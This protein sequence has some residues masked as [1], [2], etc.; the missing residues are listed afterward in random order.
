MEQGFPLAAFLFLEKA[1]RDELEPL[2]AGRAAI[3]LVRSSTDVCLSSLRRM[4]AEEAAGQRKRMFE[5]CCELVRAVPSYILHATRGGPTW[6]QMEKVL[7]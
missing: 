3:R 1:E 7:R 6:E 4:P 2:G 5:N